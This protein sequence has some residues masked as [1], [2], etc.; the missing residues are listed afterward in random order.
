MCLQKA[1]EVSGSFSGSVCL[2]LADYQLAD[3]QKIKE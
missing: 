2:K 3:W 1:A